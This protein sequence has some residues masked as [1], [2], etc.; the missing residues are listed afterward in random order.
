M[1]YTYNFRLCS[2]GELQSPIASSIQDP[3]LGFNVI[4]PPLPSCLSSVILVIYVQS[5]EMLNH[6]DMYEDMYGPFVRGIEFY[7]DGT[8]CDPQETDTGGLPCYGQPLNR[9]VDY[10]KTTFC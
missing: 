4:L 9:Y 1:G 6:R 8:W 7:V 2:I 5:L 10:R 3:V